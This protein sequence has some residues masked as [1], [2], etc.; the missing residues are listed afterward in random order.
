MIEIKEILNKI[1]DKNCGSCGEKNCTDFKDFVT[2]NPDEFYKCP[3]ILK[4]DLKEN[5]AS[6]KESALAED[7]AADVVIIVGADFD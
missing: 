3:Y 6:F 2:K 7:E 5:V 4:N 1:P